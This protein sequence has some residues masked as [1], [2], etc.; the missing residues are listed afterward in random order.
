[1]VFQ[2]TPWLL[3][4]DKWAGP[5]ANNIALSSSIGV[6]FTIAK[7][8]LTLRLN[9]TSGMNQGDLRFQNTI[10]IVRQAISTA[11]WLTTLVISLHVINRQFKTLNNI[12]K[13]LWSNI[14]AQIPDA[15][16]RPWL[17]NLA[18]QKLFPE[19]FKDRSLTPPHSGFS[20]PRM[21]TTPQQPLPY[22]PLGY[23]APTGLYGGSWLTTPTGFSQPNLWP[24]V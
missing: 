17:T 5:L 9:Q 13:G 19:R 14:I 6:G 3:K 1:M 12:S 23:I 20:E 8:A 10:E 7:T 18:I 24:R 16:I 21:P 4:L 15:L 11:L 2:N 22:S